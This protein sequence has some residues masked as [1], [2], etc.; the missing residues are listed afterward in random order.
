M[1]KVSGNFSALQNI[2]D[3]V[4]LTQAVNV[5]SNY[6]LGNLMVIIS[7]LVVLAV[8]MRFE[9]SKGLAVSSFITII[10]TIMLKQLNLVNDL[11]LNLAIILGTIFILFQMM[12]ND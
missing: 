5:A 2:S 3:L 7:F 11:T 12:K 6:W 10:L 4:S 8:T 1:I 9:T